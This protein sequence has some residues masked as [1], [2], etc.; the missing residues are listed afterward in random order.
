MSYQCPICH[1]ALI[2][3][4]TLW[5]CASGHSFDIAKEGYV[6]LMPVQHKRSKEPGDSAEMMQARRAFLDGG[7]YQPLSLAVEHA[8][9]DYLTNSAATLLDI[10]CGE[11]YYTAKLSENMQ[12]SKPQFI[13]YG[14]DIAKTAIRSAA[15]RYKTIKFCVAS[16]YRLPFINH[17][18]DA[19]LR[20]YAPCDENE[21]Q[22]VASAQAIIVT[23]TPAP[24][25][26][27]QLK[28]LIYSDVILH[29]DEQEQIAGFTLIEQRRLSYAM[30]L[31]GQQSVTLLQMTPLVWKANQSVIETMKTQALLD[32]DADFYINIYQRKV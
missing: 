16:S 20:I 28:A 12:K 10:G 7:F 21:L 31:S 13:V 19:I 3:Q 23:V 15:K 17:S 22:R 8:F 4:P 29:S 18:I 32:C 25:H 6:N 11:G 24:N 30:K 1:S 2:E 5:R 27:K 14:L 9:S 26:L